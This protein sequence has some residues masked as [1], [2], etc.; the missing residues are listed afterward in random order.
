MLYT[1]KR[2]ERSDEVLSYFVR[3]R[4][5][6]IFSLINL[7]KQHALMAYGGVEV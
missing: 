4:T 2:F 6:I 3:L 7:M 5:D 1:M